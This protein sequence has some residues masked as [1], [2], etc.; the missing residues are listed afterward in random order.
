MLLPLSAG[1][2]AALKALLLGRGSIKLFNA[3]LKAVPDSQLPSLLELLP[4]QPGG[5]AAAAAATTFGSSG[6]SGD[7]VGAE[8]SSSPGARTRGGGPAVL[9]P[10]VETAQILLERLPK[11]E[12]RDELDHWM[13]VLLGAGLEPDYRVFLPWASYYAQAS[14]RCRGGV[15]LCCQCLALCDPA[16]VYVLVC[17]LLRM[18]TPLRRWPSA[19]SATPSPYLTHSTPLQCTAARLQAGSVSGVRSVMEEVEARGGRMA[20]Q[21]YSQLVRVRRPPGWVGGWGACMHA[22]NSGCAVRRGEREGQRQ[23]GKPA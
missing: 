15:G 18:L 7:A 22:F 10:N 2:E 14:R 13:R 21:Y 3:A 5:A 20:P 8:S 12:L 11:G 16:A 9:R 23:V 6:S 4:Q 19:C 17:L 1:D